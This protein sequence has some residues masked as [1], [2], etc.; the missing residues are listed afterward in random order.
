MASR[1]KRHPKRNNDLAARVLVYAELHNQRIAASTFGLAESTVSRYKDALEHDPDLEAK[2]FALLEEVRNQS[3]L[4]ELNRGMAEMIRTAVDAARALK[5]SPETLPHIIGAL[6]KLAEIHFTKE[7]L[8]HVAAQAAQPADALGA[9]SEPA[10]P[11]T[12]R[13]LS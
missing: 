10:Q 13:V 3:W 5:P 2:F 4:K 1:S 12:E 9:S 11:P 6:D 8:D 7:H